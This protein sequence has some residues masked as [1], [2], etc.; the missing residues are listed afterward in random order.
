MNKLITTKRKNTLNTKRKKEVKRI[1]NKL[2]GLYESLEVVYN[3]EYS[4][5]NELTNTASYIS[6][7]TLNESDRFEEALDR[8]DGCIDS[9]S[10]V[11]SDK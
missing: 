1:Y 4:D 5:L 11:L 2:K 6:A 8:L 10:E 9:I 3:D 7:T